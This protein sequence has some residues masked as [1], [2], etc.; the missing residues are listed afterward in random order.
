MKRAFAALA[1][2]SGFFV[3]LSSTGCNN[4][5]NREVRHR[6]PE[7]HDRY[8]DDRDRSR[9]QDDNANVT[10]YEYQRNK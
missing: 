5:R 10:R 9:G 3:G 1:L 7:R 6:E 2:T 4:D 8:D